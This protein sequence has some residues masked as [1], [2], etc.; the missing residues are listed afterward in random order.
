M[1]VLERAAGAASSDVAR[2]LDEAVAVQLLRRDRTRPRFAFVH[3]LVQE[4]LYQRLGI[5]TRN[6]LHDQVATVVERSGG[7][8]SEIAHHRLRAATGHDDTAAIEWAV[9]AAEQCFADLAYEDA[10]DWYGVRSGSW[11]RSTARAIC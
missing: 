7:R 1:L 8:V 5:G 11:P 2:A 3:V 4:V 9:R 6:A 10:A